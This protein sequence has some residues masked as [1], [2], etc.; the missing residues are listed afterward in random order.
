LGAG[1]TAEHSM[2]GVQCLLAGAG[3]ARYFIW[4][5]IRALDYLLTRTDV[6]SKRIAVTGNSGGGTQSSYLAAF[7]PRLAAAAPSCYLT[8]WEKLWSGPG[9]QDRAEFCQF[10]QGRAGFPR[11]S[12]GLR[13][14]A[15]TD[16]HGHTRLLPDRGCQGNV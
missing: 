3:V 1:G 10:P 7:E 12:G 15:H 11:F 9:P 14:Q 16:G 2:E 5:G 6:D 4:D 8:A 13:T